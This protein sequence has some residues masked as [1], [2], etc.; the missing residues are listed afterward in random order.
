MQLY[1]VLGVVRKYQAVPY[2][3]Q[4]V[5]ELRELFSRHEIVSEQDMYQLSLVREPRNA[6]REDIL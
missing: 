2:N 4:E 6:R 1:D 5:N 3:F